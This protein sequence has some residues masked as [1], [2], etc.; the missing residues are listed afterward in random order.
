MEP[1]S[2]GLSGSAFGGESPVPGGRRCKDAYDS[3]ACGLRPAGRC[4]RLKAMSIEMK[5]EIR[6][7]QR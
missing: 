5:G 2:G 6:F 1:F 3:V 4:L 7:V